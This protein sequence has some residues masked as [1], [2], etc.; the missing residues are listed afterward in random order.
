MTTMHPH[1]QQTEDEQPVSVSV[2]SLSQAPLT[3]AEVKVRTASRKPAAIVGIFLVL[4]LGY[5]A[6]GNPFTL[7]G[8][9][10][11][12]TVPVILSSTG[13]SP[14]SLEVA[15]G[16]TIEWKNEDTIPHVL[17]FEG[18][19]FQGKQLETAPIFPGSSLTMLIPVSTAAGTYTYNSKTSELSGEIMVLDES[20]APSS[21][22]SSAMM[23]T[24]TSVGNEDLTEVQMPDGSLEQL[25]P[26]AGMDRPV[27]TTQTNIV[28]PVNIHTV[29]NP[30]QKPVE[31]L[32]SG[33]PLAQI[34]QHKPLRTTETGPAIWALLA[35]TI[36]SVLFVTRRA[37]R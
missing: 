37:F 15:A 17:T 28:M 35:S 6:L 18:M 29:S 22:A 16:T 31:P 9:I 13:P 12:S 7:P 1:W 8:Q 11:V 20:A 2:D 26:A 24:V 10:T 36:A 30:N 14:A 4:G 32:H 33:A 34:T 5:A 27:E 19:T 21:I 3:K 23:E 25:P